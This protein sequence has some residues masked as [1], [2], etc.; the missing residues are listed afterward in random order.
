MSIKACFI[1]IVAISLSYSMTFPREESDNTPNADPKPT[2]WKDQWQADFTEFLSF[3]LIGKGQ[4]SG[5]W[6]Y[7]HKNDRFFVHRENGKI[8]RYCGTIFKYQNTPC[9]QVVKNKKRYIY[10]T[11]K[12]FCCMC[13]TAE[14]GCGVVNPDWVSAGTYLGTK[15]VDGVSSYEYDIV[16]GQHNYYD[17]SVSGK[18]PIRL[19]Q[20]PLS[21]MHWDVE[22]YV[23]KITDESVFDLPSDLGDCEQKCGHASVC[24]A[25]NP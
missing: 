11:E 22:S 24:S 7:D 15:V 25:L 3:P 18:Q 13:C 20:A 17:E 16:G 8:D 9:T 19:D 6:V 1:L 5:K 21:D 23:E 14:E 4:T 12:K 2:K 10:F